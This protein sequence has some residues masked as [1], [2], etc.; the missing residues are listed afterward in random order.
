MA[1]SETEKKSDKK[2]KPLTKVIIRRLPPTIEQETFIKQV[3]PIPDYSYIYTVNGDF[4]LGENAFSRVYINFVHHDDVYSFKERFDNYVFLDAKGSEYPCVV[5]FAPFQKIPKKR[6][7]TRM[8]PKAGSIESDPYYL[9]FLE[10]L[11]KPQ[12]VD[13]KPEYTLQ[14]TSSSE[15]KNDVT[16][17]LLEYIKSKRAQRMRIREVRREERKRR[18]FDKRR[19]HFDDR[20]NRDKKKISD[21]KSPTKKSHSKSENPKAEKTEPEASAVEKPEKEERYYEKSYYKNKD[22]RYDDRRFE[23]RRKEPKPRYPRKEYPDYKSDER[24]EKKYEYSKKEHEPKTYTKKVKKY[25]EKREERKLEA[26]KA[27]QKKEDDAKVED[28]KTD[29]NSNKSTEHS[30]SNNKASEKV[31]KPETP[32]KD[33]NDDQLKSS[34]DNTTVKDERDNKKKERES[35]FIEKDDNHKGDSLNQRRIRNKDRPTIAIYRPGMLSK[36]KQNDGDTIESKE[37]SDEK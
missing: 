36:R 19:E 20:D 22:R 18:E 30:S 35:S 27:V 29:D 25:S 13:E 3:S 7:K 34:E 14:L 5:E 6:G 17:P 1:L 24:K 2:E 31:S 12:E 21:E 9:D 26:Q 15:N 32:T 28:K 10:N 23:D 37:K 4:S 11:Q 16:T 8:D 33:K